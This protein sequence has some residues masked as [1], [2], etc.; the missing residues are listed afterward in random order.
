MTCFEQQNFEGTLICNIIFEFYLCYAPLV[1]AQN[2][3]LVKSIFLQ[4]SP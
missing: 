4:K 1:Q 2:T 3:N